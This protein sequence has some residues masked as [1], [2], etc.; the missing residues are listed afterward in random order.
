METV[1][2]ESSMV[3]LSKSQ[4][5]VNGRSE[6]EKK[7]P[8]RKADSLASAPFLFFSFLQHNRLYM[9]AEPLGEQTSLDI[10]SGKINPRDD[11]K[12]KFK[13]FPPSLARVDL[14][15]LTFSSSF[16][17][18]EQGSSPTSMDGTLPMLGRSGALGL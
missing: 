1:T 10:E 17:Q 7:S 12:G 5:K 14:A 18:S 3:A 6:G 13:L 2:A 16:L 11:F 15:H 4:N 9:K 8:F